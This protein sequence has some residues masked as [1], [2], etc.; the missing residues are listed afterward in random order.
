MATQQQDNRY[1]R[2]PREWAS[3][4]PA[5]PEDVSAIQNIYEEVYKGTYPYLEYTDAEFLR[6]DMTSGHSNWYI[7]ED[8]LRQLICGCVS[9]LVDER[10]MRAYCRGMM[11]RPAWQGYGG[12]ARLFGVAFQHMLQLYKGQLRIVWGELRSASIKP[13]AV[14][15]NIGMKPVGILPWKDVFFGRRETAV[16]M[17]VYSTVAWRARDTNISLVARLEPIYL[18]AR[19]MF[20]PMAKDKVEIH[21][22]PGSLSNYKHRSVEIASLEK[23]YGY[24]EYA[25]Y[26]R[27]INSSLTIAVNKQCL[28]AEHMELHCSEPEVAFTLLHSMIEHLREKGIQFIEGKCPAN[29]P[30]MQNAFLLAG[31]QPLGYLPAWNKDVA[32][33]LD[34]DQIVFGWN[35]QTIDRKT[36]AL[37]STAMALARVY[38]EDEWDSPPSTS[39]ISPMSRG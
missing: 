5:R 10:E 35:Y 27:E 25:F 21:E 19:R 30:G 2:N 3:V 32:S 1:T 33:G 9:A 17:A 8:T 4:R 6:Q 31:M 14:A 29:S 15:E 37:S 28:N 11:L 7:L 36:T 20:K 34:V 39:S 23:A 13:Q 26:N 12:T 24:T 22:N 38:F 18:S 16:I